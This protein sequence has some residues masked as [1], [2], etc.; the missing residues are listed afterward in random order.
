[1]FVAFNPNTAVENWYVDAAENLSDK[2]RRCQKIKLYC[3]KP[4]TNKAEMSFYIV[5]P[6]CFF[7]F[8]LQYFIKELA[9]KWTINI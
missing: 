3:L 9:E 5:V 6:T 8:K 1:M 2:G 7:K 4:I